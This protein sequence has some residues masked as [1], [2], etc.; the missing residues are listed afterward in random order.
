MSTRDPYANMDETMAYPI[1]IDISKL[2]DG[3]LIAVRGASESTDTE[4]AQM[5]PEE[6]L[7]CWAQWKLGSS[8]WAN[9]FLRV[10][11]S[12]NSAVVNE[13]KS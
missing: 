5:T 7:Q 8:E 9:D 3:I 2:P 4:I 11:E 10:W 6:I 13:E 1:V 12:A